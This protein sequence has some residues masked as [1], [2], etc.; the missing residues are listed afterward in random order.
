MQF[1]IFFN[2]GDG[3]GGWSTPCPGRF[4]S[5]KE[6]R[7]PFYKTLGGTQGRSGRV[8]ESPHNPGFDP[9]TVQPVVNLYTAFAILSH[10]EAC[11]NIILWR[12]RVTTY[13]VK[14]IRI[15]HSECN[16]YPWLSS[17][18]CACAL[19]YCPILPKLSHKRNYFRKNVIQ[20]NMPVFNFS[21]M[22]V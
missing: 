16:L 8:R 3:R 21:A 12:V 6:T 10:G 18:Q 1:Y 11:I 20:H 7:Y 17:K 22:F 4:T 19:L 14:P 9:Q 13:R 15:T 2:L 5:A